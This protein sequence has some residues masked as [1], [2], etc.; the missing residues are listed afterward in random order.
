MPKSARENEDN[1]K[2]V[3]ENLGLDADDVGVGNDDDD[4]FGGEDGSEDEGD[5]LDL[6]EDGDQGQGQPDGDRSQDQGQEQLLDDLS[7][8]VTGVSHIDGPQPSQLT[9]DNKGNVV[10]VG[11]KVDDKG[12]VIGANGKI[13][14]KA[15]SERRLYDEANKARYGQLQASAQTR[16]L[17]GKL[18]QAVEIGQSLFDQ[19]KAVRE[20]KNVGESLGL[21]ADQQVEAMQLFKEGMT[22]PKALLQKL[23]TRAA[24]NGI[25]ITELGAGGNVDAQSLTQHITEEVKRALGPIQER[26]AQETQRAEQSAQLEA[27]QRRVAQ[28]TEQFFAQNPGARPY[29]RVFEAVYQATDQSGRPLHQNMSLGEVWARIQLNLAHRGQSDETRPSKRSLPGGRPAP[30]DSA[31]ELAPVDASYE[32]ILKDVMKQFQ[33]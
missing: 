20:Q 14:A 31:S 28:E 19:L 24:A 30:V 25:N 6:S 15:G 32:E 7:L 3:F 2:A 33:M 12:N 8:D 21:N 16:D 11:T 5:S 18:E 29:I 27:T 13:V 9:V 10:R 26:N 17:Q 1:K 4:I 22:N 23:L